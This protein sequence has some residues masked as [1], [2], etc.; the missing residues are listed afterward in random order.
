MH[1]WMKSGVSCTERSTFY[2]E[3]FKFL[4]LLKTN[5][6]PRETTYPTSQPET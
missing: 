3:A 6:R 1:V 4:A 5:L 2:K